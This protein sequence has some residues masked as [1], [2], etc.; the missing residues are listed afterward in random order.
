MKMQRGIQSIQPR[1]L[2]IVL[3]F[4]AAGLPVTR[5]QSEPPAAAFDLQLDT[6]N[7]ALW[8]VDTVHL[9]TKQVEITHGEADEAAVIRPTWNERDRLAADA[10]DRNIE[11]GR[12]HLYQLVE[13]RDC[14]QAESSFEID[15]PQAYIDE[16]KLEVV[17]ALQAGA[18]G[19]YLFN[20]RTFT[21]DDFAGSGGQ[22]KRFIVTAPDFNEPSDKLRAIERVSFI[23]ERN[24]SVVSAPIKIRRIAIDLNSERVTPP[25]EEIRVSNPKSFYEFTYKTQADVDRLQARISNESMDITRRL[26]SAKDGVELVPQWGQGQIPEGHTG[27]V[28]LVQS[29]GGPHH[30]DPFEVQY[31]LNIPKAYFDEGKLAVYLF[32]QAGEA[33]YYRWSGTPRPLAS[34]AEHAGQDV[35]LTMTEEDFRTQGKKRN[36]IEMIGL[37]LNRNGS[38]VTEPITLKRIAV[39][40]PEVAS[41]AGQ[42]PTILWSS[43]CSSEST[44]PHSS[45][46]VIPNHY[47][48][49]A[50]PDGQ[51]TVFRGSLTESLKIDDP[52]SAHL[53]PD[54][55]FGEFLRGNFSV[56][57]DV[58]VDD[59]EPTVLGP[60]REQPWL[61]V[62]TLF[63]QTTWTGD[64][65]FEPSVMTNVVGSPGAYFLQ[66]YSMSPSDGGTFFENERNAPTF[67]TGQWVSIKVEVDVATASVRTFQDGVLVSKGPYK[68][69]P[70]LSGAHMGLYANRLMKRATVYNRAC[71]IK[72]RPSTNPVAGPADTSASGNE[73]DQAE[74]AA[75]ELFIQGDFD[76]ANVDWEV[77]Q[78]NGAIARIGIVKE[79]PRGESALRLQVLKIADLPWRLQMFQGGLAIEK[80]RPY[81][82]SFW[83]K[84]NRPGTI[85]VN[86]MQNHDPWEHS[87]EKEISINPDWQ[88]V[89]FK[90]VG[91]WDDAN[92][93][94]TIADLGTDVG[95]I[96]WFSNC[97][98]TPEIP[99]P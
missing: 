39:K 3:G 35:V 12:L 85:K 99:R 93:R 1:M 92:A 48:Y 11:H 53:H 58:W 72:V 69:R 27:N 13:A 87:T 68:S 90:F 84:S 43:D 15:M 86:C 82:L 10:A 2:R 6:S 63:D 41:I 46:P 62:L 54:I 4:V 81:V 61:N 70:G 50:D 8:I 91:P 88:S 97:S 17:F 14:T 96:Y 23:L 49:V 95:R 66:T 79:G 37:Q 77:D 32:V 94:I 74:R 42:L 22:Y 19:D 33:G 59:L 98:L 31:T 40:L 71:S 64:S 55:Y 38:T 28:V 51:G 25:A 78:E 9:G 73:R 67:P 20:G 29:L 7:P 5:A 65:R 45:H 75:G 60:Y 26:G 30:F 80:D 52:E 89:Q 34:F 47:E 76:H 36:L 83:V 21:M 44:F 24:G 57:F 18:R 56:N 16:G